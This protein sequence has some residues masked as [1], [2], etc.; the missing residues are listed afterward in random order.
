MQELRQHNNY[1]YT[2]SRFGNDRNGNAI[3]NVNVYD[4]KLDN[5]NL[6]F[7]RRMDKYD[8]IHFQSYNVHSDICSMIDRL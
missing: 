7:N 2:V 6:C 4:Q 1:Y 8:N 3:Y 5:I